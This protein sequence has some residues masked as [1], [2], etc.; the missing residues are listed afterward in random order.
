VGGHR[1]NQPLAPNEIDNVFDASQISDM[2][3]QAGLSEDETRHGL[4]QLLPEV[5]DHFTPDGQ[6]PDDDEFSHPRGRLAQPLERL[7]AA[8]RRRAARPPPSRRPEGHDRRTPGRPMIIDVEWDPEAGGDRVPV[9]VRFGARR[10]AVVAVLDRWYGREHGWWKLDTEGGTYILRHEDATGEWT[11]AAVPAAASAPPT[12]ACATRA[13][14]GVCTDRSPRTRAPAPVARAGPLSSA[15]PPPVRAMHR[16]VE[17]HRRFRDRTWPAERERYEALAEDGQRPQTMVVACSDSRVDPQTVFGAAPGELFVVRNVAGLVPRYEPDGHHHGTSAALEFGVRVL[18]VDRLVVLGHAQCGGVRALVDGDT[19]EAGDFVTAWMRIA[20]PVLERAPRQLSR[21]DLLSHC[22]EDVVR[23]SIANLRTFPWVAQA[24]REGRLK[25]LGFRFGIRSGVLEVL[26]RGR[27][28][29]GG[30]LVV[31]RPCGSP[32]SDRLV[33]HPRQSHRE[34]RAAA[35]ARAARLHAAAVQLD[36]ALDHRE[37]DAQAAA[38]AVERRVDLVEQLEQPAE[39]V[40]SMPTPSSSTSISTVA[41]V[42]L[43][44]TAMRPPSGVYFAALPSRLPRICASRTGSAIVQTGSRGSSS[45]SAWPRAA[46]SPAAASA[47]S[48]SAAATSTRSRASVIVPRVMRLTSS[49]S[50]TRCASWPVWRIAIRIASRPRAVIDSVRS[51]TRSALVSGA[52]GLRSSCA[53]MARNSSL[54]RSA[55]RSACSTRRCS[56]IRS[57]SWYCLRRPPAPP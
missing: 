8:Q 52:S 50:S 15:G 47:A 10:L 40:G 31:P 26:G 45:D 5:V 34:G 24:E 54:R 6:V 20:E 29:R 38:A 17:G 57:R 1:P 49:R 32:R 56:A 28:V 16:F 23:L 2:A 7:R 46:Q 25:L 12:T 41:A 55:S 35:Q 44:R 39:L 43:E 33:H 42:V 4:A 48:R 36:Q 13:A 14:R 19:G 21:D 9:A 18:R 53:S 30:R 3:S 51:T 22:E 27:A 37:P 11:L